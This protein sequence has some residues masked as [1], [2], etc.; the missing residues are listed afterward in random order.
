[1]K[2]VPLACIIV[3]LLQAASHAGT[4]AHAITGASNTLVISGLHYYGF[5]GANDEAVQLTNVSATPI[6]LDNNWTLRD[7]D[8]D[9][10]LFPGLTLSPGQRL[11]VANSAPAFAQQ[12]GFPPDVSYAGALGFANHGGSVSLQRVS[13]V[14][15]DT[16]NAAGGA[17]PAGSGSSTYRS[18]ERIDTGLP[19]GPANWAGANP[20]VPVAF[21]ANSNPITGTPKAANSVAVPATPSSLGPVISE[22]AW[23][24]TRANSAHEWIEFYNNTDAP[25]SLTDWELRVVGGSTVVL[26]GTMPARGFFLLQRNA[27][28]FSSGAAADQTASFSLSNSGAA[29]QLV[30]PNAEIVD[31]LVYG[32]GAPRAGWIGAPLQPYTVTQTIPD[33]GQILMRRLDVTTGLPVADTDTA[34]DWLNDRADVFA[35]RRPIYPGWRYEQFLAPAAGAGALTLAMAP[36]ASFDVVS[37]T[38]SAAT[39]S[40]D[41][42]SF[43]FENAHLG[44]LL[45][46]KAGAGVRVRVL[47]DGSPVGGLSDQTRWICQRITAADASGNSGCWFMRSDSANKVRT[48][49]AYLHAK[50]ALIDGARLLMGSENFGFR[51]MP[52]DDKSDGTAGQRGVI[53][54]TDAPALVARAQAIFAADIDMAN[55]DIT[56]WCAACAPYG[57]PDVAF[58]PNYA[59]GGISYTLRIPPFTIGSPVSMTLFSSPENHLGVPG[60]VLGL[61]NLAGAGDEILVQQLDEPY[62]W[63]PTA[64]NP[65]TDP[66][67]RV[68]A[69]LRAAS[70]GA[71]VRVLL[72][73]HYDDASAARS[74]AATVAHL[75]GQAQA[76]GW[77]VRA[78][79][80]NPTGLGIHNK[81]ILFTLGGRRFAH[82]GSWN[83]TEISAKRDRELSLL[84]ES[85]AAHAYLREAFWRDY[86][87][88]QPVRL[89]LVSKDYKPVTHP[90]I[91]EVM[92]NPS[93]ANEEGREWIEI[94]NPTPLPINLAGYKIGDAV[95]RGSAG[96]GMFAFPANAVLQPNDAIVIAQN[97]AA[98]FA[99]WGLKPDYE[100]A[101][102]DASVPD[103]IPY[104]AWAAGTIGLANLGD[105]VVLLGNNDTILD[106]VV[107]LSGVVPGTVPYTAA[108]APGHT[109]QRWP[110]ASDTNNCAVDFRDQAVPSPGSVP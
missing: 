16:A 9:T 56:R 48:R 35:A 66:N 97:S 86:Q 30:N 34:Q 6:T 108:I 49:Y 103:L 39:A 18:M 43:T 78:A 76:N 89:P 2:A 64:S 63:G 105:E 29:L 81:M 32:D 84:I 12:F 110:P 22:V 65:A 67:P 92:I 109:L 28:T 58:T 73:S 79:R 62:Y 15:L 3:L 20:A 90:L 45:S 60:G 57:S 7:A 47:L 107:W 104:T 17:W 10:W 71:Q 85:D 14:L 4:T 101:N 83:G 91:S 93:G 24:G 27:A 68:Q 61:I 11:W 25:I 23:G 33:D 69:V 42:Q 1:M 95:V 74:N 100:I 40:I 21:D 70:R 94:Y 102:Y 59:S 41:L 19:D 26:S 75:L 8:N 87:L 5:D 52:A 37:Q 82:V 55:R 13:P 36:E 77:D 106:A 31:T 88:S 44:D 38:L 96:E 53:A 72:D 46:A 98:Y 50:F 54:V 80:G 99:D 51:G